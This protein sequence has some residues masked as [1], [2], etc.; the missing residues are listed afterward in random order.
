MQP[1]DEN[2]QTCYEKVMGTKVEDPVQPD[3]EA[4]CSYNKGLFCSMGE[5]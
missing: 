5:F 3:K 4:F 2:S 1:K